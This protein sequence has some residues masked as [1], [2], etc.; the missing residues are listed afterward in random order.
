MSYIRPITHSQPFVLSSDRPMHKVYI[1]SVG[2]FPVDAEGYTYIIVII[3]SFT[4]YVTLHRCKDTTAKT[5]GEACLT[6]AVYMVF[7][8][9]CIQI[10]GH[11]M[12]I[13]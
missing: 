7:Q 10:T 2:P 3:D 6:I 13:F 8:K 9:R 1:D 12:L 4:R 11:N 5:A